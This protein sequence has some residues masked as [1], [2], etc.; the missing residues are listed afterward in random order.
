MTRTNVEQ[1]QSPSYTSLQLHMNVGSKSPG[2]LEDEDKGEPK[3]VHQININ[4]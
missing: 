1:P 3:A 4:S 2:L